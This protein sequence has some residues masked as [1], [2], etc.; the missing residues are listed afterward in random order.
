MIAKKG[1]LLE[2]EVGAGEEHLGVEF[3]HELGEFGL[4][5]FGE[6]EF[7]SFFF[8]GDDGAEAEL[9]FTADRARCDV[10]IFVILNLDSTTTVGFVDGGSH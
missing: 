1:G 4:G 6:I 2:V 3:A 8:F 9:D 10:V 5:N 7:R